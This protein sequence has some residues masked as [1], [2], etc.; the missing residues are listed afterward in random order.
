[1]SKRD[2][3]REFWR[4]QASRY[5]RAIALLNRRFDAMA[6]D[7]AI[8]VAGSRAVLEIAAG[9]GL[10]THRLAAQAGH[11]VATDRSVEM[12]EI[13]RRRLTEARV[14]DVR[15]ELADA[16]ALPYADASFDTVVM[17]NVLHLLPDPSSTLAEAF[18]VL[19]PR[20]RLCTPTFFYGE[21][22]VSQTISWA[23]GLARLPVVTRLSGSAL[24]ETTERANFE[25]V[26]MSRFSGL[27][28]IWLVVDYC[29]LAGPEVP[30][31]C[32]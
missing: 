27:L 14:S 1:M 3:P 17:A 9:T 4:T 2:R 30:G 15:V 20:G 5:D 24:R 11:V 10:V 18:R 25:V 7:T 19:R 26:A 28:P 6:E 32:P 13:S 12:L 8:A 31:G 16:L 29:D 22:W 23:L 21:A